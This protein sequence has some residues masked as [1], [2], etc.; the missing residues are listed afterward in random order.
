MS[1]PRSAMHKLDGRRPQ[2]PDRADAHAIALA[3][4]RPTGY[5]PSHEEPPATSAFALGFVRIVLVGSEEIA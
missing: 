5:N 3:T 4:P 1:L 2:P